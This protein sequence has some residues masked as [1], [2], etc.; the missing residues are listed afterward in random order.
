MRKTIIDLRTPEEYALGHVKNSVNIPLQELSGRIDEIKK[1]ND[2]I[3][4]CC[5]S[6]KRSA[7]AYH[8]LQCCRRKVSPK[9]QTEAHG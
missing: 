4:L 2:E 3:I 6:G 1:I 8:M 5:A 9:Y 7:K